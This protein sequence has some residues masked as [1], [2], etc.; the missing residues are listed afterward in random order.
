[1]LLWPHG[2]S[3]CCN[4]NTCILVAA[5]KFCIR[6]LP[7]CR[8]IQAAL[9]SLKDSAKVHRNYLEIKKFLSNPTPCDLSFALIYIC[10]ISEMPGLVNKKPSPVC[11]AP[12]KVRLL[13]YIFFFN[14]VDKYNFNQ[15]SK[16]IFPFSGSGGECSYAHVAASLFC[17][18]MT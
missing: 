6:L 17:F 15:K 9:G 8:W 2:T 11:C 7:S 12:G 16:D 10:T 13:S 18:F 3:I 1:M 14:C 4:L 5:C